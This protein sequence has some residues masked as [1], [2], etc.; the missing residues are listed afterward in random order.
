MTGDGGI[1]GVID[2]DGLGLRRGLHPG[3]TMEAGALSV[4][5]AVQGL[6]GVYGKKASKGLFITNVDAFSQLCGQG[7]PWGSVVLESPIDGAAPRT[8]DLRHRRP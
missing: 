4:V 2:E 3:Q 8:I 6:V 1:D 5:P 7:Y